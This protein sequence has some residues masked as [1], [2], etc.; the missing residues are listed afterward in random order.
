MQPK[1]FL[2]CHCVTAQKPVTGNS[3]KKTF[4]LTYGYRTA[5][6]HRFIYY[7]FHKASPALHS[8]GLSTLFSTFVVC[9]MEPDISRN[10]IFNHNFKEPYVFPYCK[11]ATKDFGPGS[12]GPGSGSGCDR[13]IFQRQPQLPSP[14]T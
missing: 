8:G 11:V 9:N 14:K 13:N 3:L 7:Y 1:I 6:F 4:N 12:G 10:H 2:I 5:Y